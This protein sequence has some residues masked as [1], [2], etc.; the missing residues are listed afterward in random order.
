MRRRMEDD[1][2]ARVREKFERRAGASGVPHEWHT[3]DGD[4]V[5]VVSVFARPADLAVIGQE[6]PDRGAFGASPDLAENVVLASGRPVLI[7]PYVGAYP[8]AGRRVMIAWDASREAARAVADALPVLQA[9]QSVVTLSANPGSGPRPDRH[10]DLPGADIARHLARHGVNVEVHRIE[11]RDVSIADMLLNRIADESIDL[12]V[13]GAYGHARVREIWLGGVTRDLLRHMTVPCCWFHTDPAVVDS[14]PTTG[15]AVRAR[16]IVGASGDG[17]ASMKQSTA[18][19]VNGET[20][21]LDVHP[22]EPLALALRN[23][24]GLTGVKVGCGLEQCGAC[25][26][27]VDG[28]STLSC[29]RPA[30]DFEGRRIETVEG[31]GTAQSP[32]PVQRALLDE[33]A[34]QCGYCT[35]GLVVAITGLLRAEPRPDDAAIPDRALAPPVPVRRPS[36]SV[37]GG[38]KARRRGAPMSSKSEPRGQPSRGTLDHH[39]GGRRHRGPLR[40]GGDRPADHDRG[41]PGR[42]PGAGCALRAHRDGAPA[43]RR[44]A[45]RGLHLRQQL[46][47]AVGRSGASRRGDRPS[48]ADCARGASPR[49]GC[50]DPGDP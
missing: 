35:P 7:V 34:A 49:R 40:Q 6:N 17:A 22:D 14:G 21:V 10:G 38:A 8:H 9:A 25:A 11:T 27:L 48:G 3:A 29:V 50:R 46:H 45:R 16:S 5:R 36:E 44:L 43:H 30:A 24:L 18:L 15:D 20:H 2:R 4:A 13:M 39:P 1:A 47:G 12:L 28:A 37:A 31:L 26:V 19:H 23:R 41:G 33:G 32:G 42:G